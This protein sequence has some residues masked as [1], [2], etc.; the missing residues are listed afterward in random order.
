M[1]SIAHIEGIKRQTVERSEGKTLTL[2]TTFVLFFLAMEMGRT[3]TGIS[4]DLLL[5]GIALVGVAVLPYLLQNVEKAEF[6]VWIAGRAWIA[7][8]AIAIGVLFNQ[9]IGAVLPEMLRFAPMCLL[10][11]SA[12]LSCQIHFYR[13]LR[14]RPTR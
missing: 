1:K 8:F 9:S 2:D 4:V 3:L 10:I 14:F 7:A 5:M 12:M 6:G 13:F 11:V